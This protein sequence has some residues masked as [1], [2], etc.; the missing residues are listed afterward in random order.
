MALRGLHG[1][2]EAAESTAFYRCA[3]DREKPDT[4]DFNATRG[5]DEGHGGRAH[6][7]GSAQKR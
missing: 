2:H 3:D 6:D 5:A 7:A 1:E 4:L